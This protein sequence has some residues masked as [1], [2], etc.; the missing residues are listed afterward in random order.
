MLKGVQQVGLGVLGVDVC[1]ANLLHVEVDGEHLGSNLVPDNGEVVAEIHNAIQDGAGVANSRPGISL[2]AGVLETLVHLLGSLHLG[3][4]VR[5]GLG[6]H[7]LHGLHGL[8]LTKVHA[9]VADLLVVAGCMDGPGRAGVEGLEDAALHVLVKVHDLPAVLTGI[10]GRLVLAA[11]PH[12]GIALALDAGDTIND[13]REV[14][15]DILA[16]SE[17]GHSPLPVLLKALLHD[18]SGGLSGRHEHQIAPSDAILVGIAHGLDEGVILEELAENI[19][20]GKKIHDLLIGSSEAE[21]SLKLIQLFVGEVV[22]NGT[23][24][25]N[26]DHFGKEGG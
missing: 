17:S 8:F 22:E 2:I 21:G 6:E 11:V 26:G 12:D 19:V 23:E 24:L 14:V 25:G 16:E 15:P 18:G 7:G 4:E 10:A 5:D 13:G 1:L 9:D 3:K 20:C